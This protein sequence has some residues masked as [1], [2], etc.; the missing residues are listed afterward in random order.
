MQNRTKEGVPG[1]YRCSVWIP[2]ALTSVKYNPHLALIV[3]TL[4]AHAP[5][6]DA[7]RIPYRWSGYSTQ[8][9]LGRKK[10]WSCSKAIQSKQ[11]AP[12]IKPK[13]SEAKQ[14][15]NKTKQ[16]EVLIESKVK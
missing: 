2:Q 6:Q 10:G 1:F 4:T 15:Y 13:Q 5:P 14:N 7:I 3:A 11:K 8:K 12:Q 9:I 16:N